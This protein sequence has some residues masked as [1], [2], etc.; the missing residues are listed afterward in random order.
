M[1][2]KTTMQENLT[3]V[4]MAMFKKT[5]NNSVGEDV[6]KNRTLVQCWWKCKLV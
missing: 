1:R 2:I 4:R 5:R 6:E 3:P